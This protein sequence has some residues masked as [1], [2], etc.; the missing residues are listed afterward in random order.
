MESK[1]PDPGEM[2]FRKKTFPSTSYYNYNVCYLPH[3]RSFPKEKMAV[4]VGV[5][6]DVSH[7]PGVDIVSPLGAHVVLRFGGEEETGR[8][9]DSKPLWILLKWL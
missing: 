5:P 3:L 6:T 9:V 1:R 2:V 7:V 8:S 4:S